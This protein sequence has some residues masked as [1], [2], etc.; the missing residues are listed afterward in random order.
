MKL[1]TALCLTAFFAFPAFAQNMEM[2]EETTVGEKRAG[3]IR[4]GMILPKVSLTEATG[5]VD[6]PTALRNSYAA[7]LN[8]ETYEVVA[9]DARLTSLAVEEAQSLD[10]D[11]ILS[12]NLEQ[13]E[14]K[15]GGGLF[16]KVL[17]DAGR[18]ITNEAGNAVPYGGNSATKRV[19][20]TTAR[21]AIINTGY[22]LS[23]MSVKVNKN[24][25]FTLEYNL[26]ETNGRTVFSNTQKAKAKKNNATVLSQI[27]EESINDTVTFLRKRPGR[28][29]F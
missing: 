16:G 10:C 17:G 26:A 11:Y 3:V 25:Q 8:S 18:Q 24:D 9:L 2:N 4:I 7:L 5:D 15:K 23:D 1:L 21:S 13:E 14:K 27:I 22:T 12:V 28:T 20:S 29:K 6:A 19:V